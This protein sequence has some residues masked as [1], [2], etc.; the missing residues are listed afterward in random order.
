MRAAAKAQVRALLKGVKKQKVG[1]SSSQQA[2]QDVQGGEDDEE[3]A[4]STKKA[5]P[6]SDANACVV[7]QTYTSFEEGKASIRKAFDEDTL[8]P[9]LGK[10]KDI[11]T[12]RSKPSGYGS[13]GRG[14][15]DWECKDGNGCRSLY[16][17]I[18]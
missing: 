11:M 7:A 1:G 2:V 4:S 5:L 17:S 10:S 13:G 18:S 15:L 9:T 3:D 6:C 8:F 12:H 14:Y 16:H